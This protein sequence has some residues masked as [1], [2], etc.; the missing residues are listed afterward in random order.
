MEKIKIDINNYKKEEIDIIANSLIKGEVVAY[1]TDTVYGLGCI[2]TN[3]VAVKRIHKIKR[4]DS[5]KP[6][7]V[8]IKSYSMLHDLCKISAKQEKYIRS[9]W[10]PSARIAQNPDLS[11]KKRPT[12]FILRSKGLLPREILGVS[13][14]L[15]VRLPK[16][17][18]LITILKKINAPLVSTS[19]NISGKKQI[20]DLND[21][22]SYFTIYKP[23]LIIDAGKLKKQRPSSVVDIRDLED[24]KILR[25]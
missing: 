11:H 9:V 19:L 18:F 2:A 6:L 25:K 21:I 20:E 4:R 7:L 15:A 22:E 10:P 3:R 5:G 1:P 23:D 13:N 17:D 8:L 24:I 16:N 14:S 12:T